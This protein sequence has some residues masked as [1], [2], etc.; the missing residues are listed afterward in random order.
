[1]QLQK[2]RATEHARM[3]ELEKRVS[4]LSA[5]VARGG[6]AQ[7]QPVAEIAEKE[8]GEGRLLARGK[9]KVAWLCEWKGLQVVK[10]EI[11]NV[12]CRSSCFA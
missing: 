5:P 8:L 4:A 9:F 3:E 6:S 7:Q 10:L 1:M 2:D 12:C 11:D